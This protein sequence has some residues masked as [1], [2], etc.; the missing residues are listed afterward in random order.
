MKEEPKQ[1]NCCTPIGQIKRYVDCVG[2]DRNPKQETLEESALNFAITIQTREGTVSRLN[3]IEWYKA[4][5]KYQAKRMYSEE[6]VDK[7][8]QDFKH[9]LVESTS[10]SVKQLCSGAILGLNRL[11]QFKSK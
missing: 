5:A 3:A 2:C 1:D 6:E 11:K 4:G 7:Q 8:I 10:D 9:D